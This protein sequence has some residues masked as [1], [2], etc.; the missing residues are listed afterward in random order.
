MKAD[1]LFQAIGGADEELLERSEKKSEKAHWLRWGIIAACMVIVACVAVVMLNNSNN[2]DTCDLPSSIVVDG[3]TYVI[4][5]SYTAVSDC[6]DGFEYSGVIGT[7]NTDDEYLIGCNY[8]I[9]EAIPEWIYVY[10]EVWDSKN[11]ASMAYVR[12]VTEDIR[13]SNFIRY[14]GQIYV[15]MWSDWYAK[16]ASYRE[17]YDRMEERYG[18]RVETDTPENCAF[19]GKAH[20]EETDR[21]PQIQLGVNDADYDG[22]EVY[23]NPDDNQVLYVG[24]SW[25]TA[26]AEESG[27]TL[28]T[29]YDIFI[30]YD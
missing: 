5:S 7:D 19:V 27:E 22:A 29:G 28:H 30:L 11:N 20:L 12:F 26:T 4:S 15:S 23:A 24:T 21:I 14:N 16:D 25:Y 1:K 17:K 18:I 8:Y 9:N 6:P 3:T 2:T 13:N 10:C